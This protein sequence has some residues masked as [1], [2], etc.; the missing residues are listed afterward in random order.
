MK[1]VFLDL[2]GTLIDPKEGI[3]QSLQHALSEMGMVD[4]PHADDLTWCIGPPL[5]NS[6]PILLGENVDV[7]EAIAHY[8]A[9]YTD[10]AM[11]L[12]E[13]YDGI[14]EMFEEL[15]MM[16]LPLYI[17][18]AKPH[19][20]ANEIISHFGIDAYVQKLYGPE[21]DGTHNDKG[22]LLAHALSETGI[23]PENAVMIGDRR[24]D[25]FAAKNNNITSIGALWGYGEADE[26]HMAE[27][28]LLAGDPVELPELVIEALNLS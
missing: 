11:Y 15:L 13:P 14:G 21:L 5:Q 23:A 2:D 26:L 3:T 22:D 7:E 17:A 27:A 1:G 18:T 6:F 16:E 10:E 19:A 20:Y 28:D 12:A 4:I 24:D 25:V 8:R 9:H